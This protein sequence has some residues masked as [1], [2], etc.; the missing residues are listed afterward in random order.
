M[1][2]K[3]SRS[4][5][6]PVTCLLMAACAAPPELNTPARSPAATAPDPAPSAA[7]ASMGREKAIVAYRNYI[8]RY[9]DGPEHDRITRRLADLLVEQASDM[10]LA[11]ATTRDDPAQLKTAA[12]QSY[13]EAVS[14][15]EYLLNKYPDGPDTTDLLYQL[16]RAYAESGKS[17]QA[18]TVIERLLLLEPGTSPKLY[19]DTR[20]RRGELLF[21]EG[22]YLE[23]G[24]SYQAVVDLGASV[25]V[26]E[27]ALYKL[28]W[29]L[30]KQERY[31]DA[32]PVLVEFLD[33]KI[34][35]GAAFDTQLVRLPP[36]DREQAA[37]VF[38]VI[39]MSCARLDG[40]DSLDALF[41][42]YGSRGYADH[43][44]LDLAQ[45]YVEQEQISEAA[46][47]WRV[48]AQ[49]DPLGSEAPRLTAR[50][51]SLYRQAGFQQRLVEA[52]AVFVHDYGMS[53]DFWGVHSPEDFPDVLQVLQ[54]SLKELAQFY[55]EQARTTHA[56]SDY[57]A[58]EQW[59]RDYLAAFGD[60]RGA[61]E[62]TYQLAELLYDTG[63]YQQAID[64]YARSAW[65]RGD[66]PHA[67]DAA[68]GVL[69][70]SDRVLQH[71]D[72]TDKGAIAERATAAALRFVTAYPAHPAAPGLLAQT[73]TDMLELQ[74]YDAAIRVS[75]RVLTAAEA[76]PAL[77]QAAWSMQA[78][79]HYGLGDYVAAGDAYRAALQLASQDDPR[80]SALQEGLASATYKQAE[81][82]FLQGDKPAAVALYLQAAQLA[83]GPSLRA[84]AQYDAATALLAQESWT[85][86]I[87]MLE[88]FRNDYPDDPL[89]TEVTRKLAYA[90]DRGNHRS[91]AAA[92]Y[93][94]LGQDR[95][96]ADALQREALL[97]A[98]A[99]YAQTGPLRQ[100]IYTRELY[101]ER[102]PEPALTA[103][104][105][106]QQLAGLEAG[107]GNS[108]KWQ[109][110]LEEIIRLDRAAGAGST[111]VPAARAALE[112]AENRIAVFRQVQLV[113][114]VQESLARK[115]RVMK[116]A[117]QAFEAAIDY[118]VTP[119][120]TAATYQIASMYDELGHALLTSERPESLTAGE[121]A[122]YNLL[123]AE[124]AAPFEQ[125]AI[126]IYTTN[127]ER[128]RGDQ[129]D[130]WVEKSLLRLG[131]LQAGQ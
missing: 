60:D 79:A 26:Y 59:Y 96:Q 122:E 102:F 85:D 131:E 99:I 39:S 69:R 52:E 55:H 38:R 100:A 3:A 56:A 37:D 42:R 25:P 24:Q 95:Q 115:L 110:W 10:Q 54:S 44:Y 49:R 66:H 86:A 31:A 118:G 21:S 91:Q 98:A 93:L 128:F 112:L 11:A 9:P 48:L 94:R 90:Y 64:E 40:V 5:A 116:Q 83:P 17:Q 47:T 89:Q 16:S 124:Q 14:R 62:M 97:Q 36:A 125:Q 70:A 104:E 58:A 13:D 75:K 105:V 80:R 4:L 28:G 87:Q 121:L 34:P 15:Y 29:S 41:R 46:R 101:L 6:V 43:I 129:P 76:P 123:L 33:R 45:F 35:P 53:S 77:G 22:A 82:T 130:P 81:L 117:Q 74:Q 8:A 32:L 30:F 127:A 51:L 108:G 84:K 109:H 65:S 68:L 107:R 78:Q 61:A 119:V 71:A 12:R 19:A 20:F 72:A 126:A 113:N 57:R 2:T 114:P 92:E 23:A 67:A 7:P 63:R 103:V 18:L 106:M 120:T 27:Q 73:G 88:Q 1:I 111:R 50:A